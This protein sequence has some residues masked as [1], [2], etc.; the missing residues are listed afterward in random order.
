M[1]RRLATA[2]PPGATPKPIA[3][4]FIHKKYGHWQQLPI[5]FTWSDSFS[6][7]FYPQADRNPDFAGFCTPPDLPLTH[8]AGLYEARGLPVSVRRIG[9]RFRFRSAPRRRPGGQARARRGRWR[10][11]SARRGALDQPEPGP[12]GPARAISM[13]RRA[14]GRNVPPASPPLAGGGPVFSIEVVVCVWVATSTSSARRPSAL[15]VRGCAD[16]SCC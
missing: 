3:A 11:C 5:T 13:R 14:R 12:R 4:C 10:V 2:G 1:A 7:S 9:A 15:R 16:S 6:A 8:E